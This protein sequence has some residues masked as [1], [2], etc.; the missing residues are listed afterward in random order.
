MAV[1]K[2]YLKWPAA[3][4]LAVFVLS[5]C[6]RTPDAQVI[7][8]DGL[9]MG[10]SF[11]LRWVDTRPERVEELRPLVAALLVEINR[12]MSTYIEDSEL[13]RF[14]QAPAGTRMEV[15]EALAE[16]VGEALRIST[17]SNGAF[18]VTVGPLVNL[19]G[20]GPDG[21]IIKAPSADTINA[22]RART[23]YD[24][25]SL[26]GRQLAKRG[27]QYVD[28]SAIAKGY[29]VDRLAALL[30]QQGVESYLVE[31][32]GELRAAGH[33]PDGQPWRIAIESPVAGER[34][35]ERVI[36][37]SDVGIATSG[38]YRNYFEEDGQRFS[39]TI[40]PRTGY[41]I[42]H[43]L[44][45]VT[46][47]RERCAEADALATTL[48]VLGDEAGYDFAVEQGIAAFFIIKQADGFVEKATPEFDHYLQEVN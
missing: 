5:G 33:K 40:D 10:T 45:S 27:D 36:A 12:Q 26:E 9:T 30:Q 43:R 37:V 28:L 23:G 31:I 47:L 21:R 44:A 34:Q 25:L 4:L 39:H 22:T 18:D 35:V 41:P 11:S 13:S 6:Q 46:V 17:L 42:R 1:V 19:W 8:F 48:M 20:F 32:G 7:G 38:D 15:S 14:N 29:A 2:H 24:N 3:L 16:V